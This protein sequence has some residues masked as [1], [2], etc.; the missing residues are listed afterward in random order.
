MKP[1]DLIRDTQR[2]FESLLM[3]HARVAPAHTLSG[4][5]CSQKRV[6]TVQRGLSFV[7]DVIIAEL[8][9]SNFPFPGPRRPHFGLGCSVIFGAGDV[10][11]HRKSSLDGKLLQQHSQCLSYTDGSVFVMACLN[12]AIIRRRNDFVMFACVTNAA[13]PMHAA[14]DLLTSKIASL[15][16][17]SIQ[18]RV[19]FDT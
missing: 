2:E 19:R 6:G 11:G 1:G 3:A 9:V 12:C 8:A 13:T 4:T 17:F 16:S 15:L 7:R 5:S 18:R 14:G 10:A